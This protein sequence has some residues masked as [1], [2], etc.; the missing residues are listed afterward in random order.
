MGI[1]RRLE[2]IMTAKQRIENIFKGELPDHL[3]FAPSIYE[4]CAKFAGKTPSEVAQDGELLAKAQIASYLYYKQDIVTVGID[5][6]NIEA[7]ALGCKIKFHIDSNYV[8]GIV[9]HPL[10]ED[11]NIDKLKI[12]N[13]ESSGRM[14]MMIKAVDKVYRTIGKEVSVNAPVSGPFS[15]AVELR[16]IQNL[17]IDTIEDPKYYQEL[18]QFNLKIISDYAQ[19]LIS[20][21]ADITIFESW[22]TTPI[23]SNPFFSKYILPYEIHLINKIKEIGAE[24]VA[25]I[26]GGDAYAFLDMILETNASLIITPYNTHLL[27]VLEKARKNKVV[28]RVNMDSRKFSTETT[29]EIKPY[30]RKIISEL[31]DKPYLILGC[32]VVTYETPSDNILCISKLLN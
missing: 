20:K 32:G 19:H 17:I 27:E 11:R 16:T 4:H 23:V 31:K 5:I 8:P 22:A 28:V 13:S 29:K 6:Y 21:R 15:L 1:R 12:P 30:A 3:S 18:M 14:P 9:S 26:I 2:N 25:F 10:S 24:K 7:E